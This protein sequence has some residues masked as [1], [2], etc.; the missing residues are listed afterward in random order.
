MLFKC[1]RNPL[2]R[3]SPCVIYVPQPHFRIKIISMY[4]SSFVSS[5]YTLLSVI[6][7]S[8]LWNLLPT[9]K[10]VFTQVASSSMYNCDV[11]SAESLFF[12]IVTVGSVGM[13]LNNLMMSKLIELSSFSNLKF[14]TWFYSIHHISNKSICPLVLF[15]LLLLRGHELIHLLNA[16]ESFE[17]WLALFHSL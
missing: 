2:R 3:S 9:W 6:P 12:S 8:C 16:R 13:L 11:V 10:Y 4:C 1:C 5:M 15:Q 14:L 7:N 17:K